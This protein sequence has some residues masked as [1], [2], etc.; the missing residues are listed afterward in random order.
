M[1]IPQVQELMKTE[2]SEVFTFHSQDKSYTNNIFSGELCHFVWHWG[3]CLHSS[4]NNGFNRK[5]F[6]CACCCWCMLIPFSNRPVPISKLHFLISYTHC[7]SFLGNMLLKLLQKWV[8]IWLPLKVWYLDWLQIRHIHLS[9]SFKDFVCNLQLI[10]VLCETV[11]LYSLNRKPIH[12]WS[13]QLKVPS[14]LKF[15]CCKLELQ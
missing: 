9:S 6:Q 12:L 4:H 11:A 10:L 1:I 14:I 2:L 8:L 13:F 7:F 3:S 5:W 15:T